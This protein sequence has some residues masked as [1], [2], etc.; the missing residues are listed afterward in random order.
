MLKDQKLVNIAE[1]DKEC[2]IIRA[3]TDAILNAV[4]EIG[5]GDI[6]IG[7]VRAFE[8]GLIDVPFSPSKYN[9]N[10][11][12]PARDNNGAI[13]F[14]DCGDLPFGQDIKDF[15]MKKLEERAKTE[16]RE[17]SFE[18]VIDDVYAI[19]AGNLVGRPK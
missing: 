7:S 18:M 14:L 19:Q 8:A 11:V 12:M 2:E 16:K 6:A 5:K 3:E 9:A 13:R 1:V 15:N 4:T 17:V 10:K